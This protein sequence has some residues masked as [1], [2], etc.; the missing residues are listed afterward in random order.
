LPDVTFCFELHQPLRLRRWP[1]EYE[2]SEFPAERLLESYFD[3]EFTKAIFHR[4]AGKSY[5]PATRLLLDLVRL[6]KKAGKS[7]KLGFSLSGNFI[8]QCEIFE[9]GLLDVFRELVDTGYV[10]LLSET[11]Y[12]SLSYFFRSSEEFEEQ[13]RMH[14]N[15]IKRLFGYQPTTFQNT[16]MIY[17]NGVARR[18]EEL[19][20]KGIYTEGTEKILGGGRSPNFAYR[21][22][23]CNH[24]K[25]LLRNYQL[26][27]DIA[28]RFSLRTWPGWPVTAEKYARWLSDTGGD[29]ISIFMDFE[30][31]G[32]HHW[33]ATGIFDF[34]KH[35]PRELSRYPHLNS[36]TPS[37]AIQRHD[38]VGE[39]S[40]QDSSPVSWADL[41]R[42]TSAWLLNKMQLESFE[43]LGK[44]EPQLKRLGD[45]YLMKA[46]RYLQT[47]DHIYYM[48]TKGGGTGEVHSY[49][50]PYSSPQV[51]YET[52]TKVISDLEQ[53]VGI[54]CHLQ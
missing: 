28:F 44:L 20:F 32:E 42:D 4:A 8:E 5:Y 35:L 37:E 45:P 41:E 9:P 33:E 15:L 16:E 46:W 49:F 54:A 31:L 6:S 29:C 3:Y 7:F 21:P 27:D 18:A 47:S 2:L 40:V 24:I 39:I 38:V 22:H 25:L 13:V 30:T 26:T 17:C 48:S 12:H 43:R 10:E 52:F 14:Q 23:G 53:R 11:Y 19:G 1:R 36:V 34:L 50:S 51:A